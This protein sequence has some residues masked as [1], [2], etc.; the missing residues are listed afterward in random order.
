MKRSIIITLSLIASIAVQLCASSG[1]ARGLGVLGMMG[2]GAS[3]PFLY[4]TFTDTG[5]TLITAHTPEIGGVWTTN[6]NSYVKILT[7]DRVGLDPNSLTRSF[8]I[9]GASPQS[10]DY[11][12]TGIGVVGSTQTDR[13]LGVCGRMTSTSS[14]YCAYVIAGASGTP[15]TLRVAKVVSGT[16]TDL[17]TVS[18]TRGHGISLDYVFNLTMAG[19]SITASELTDNVSVTVYDSTYTAAGSAGAHFRGNGTY[20]YSIEAQ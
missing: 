11:S 4:D 19:S 1:W 17:G 3:G 2:G 16:M 10:A 20:I 13:N 14:G 8:A 6:N 5:G 18:L 9:N 7:G 12:V 15:L